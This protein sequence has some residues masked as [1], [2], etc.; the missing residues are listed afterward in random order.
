MSMKILTLEITNRSPK[1]GVVVLEMKGSIHAGPDC[2]LLSQEVDKLIQANSNRVVLD[3]TAVT[4]IDSAA[5]GSIVTCFSKVKRAGGLL[6]LAG[7]TGMV[8]G[9]LKLTQIDKVI[10]I[11]PTAS[12]AANGIAPA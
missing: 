7:A 3:L 11:F 5:I 6:C 10:R 1:P 8:E 12:E 2:N 9:T 4:H